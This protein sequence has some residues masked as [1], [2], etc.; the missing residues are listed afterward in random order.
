MDDLNKLSSLDSILKGNEDLK[1]SQNPKPIEKDEKQ[2]EKTEK[3]EKATNSTTYKNYYSGNI[4][5]NVNKPL[6]SDILNPSEKLKK[7]DQKEENTEKKE[8]ECRKD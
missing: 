8:I 6:L 7:E 2:A 4:E 1:I 5:D 3:E